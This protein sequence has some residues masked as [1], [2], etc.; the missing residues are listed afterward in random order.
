MKFNEVIKRITGL[1]TPVFGISWNP[2][3]TDRDR[4]KS[5]VAFLEDRR[6]LYN[7]TEMEVPHRC[8]QSILEIRGFL[9]EQIGRIENQEFREIL[10]GMRAACRKF[11][12]SVG[13]REDIVQHG[14]T[15]GHW[16]SW[17]FNGAVGELRG[18]FGIH[19]VKI[20]A[21]YGLDIEND[22]SSILP[23]AEG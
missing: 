18:V 4:A 23:I 5:I 2:E 22:L 9:T 21:M 7:P 1:S 17:A 13:E 10:K 11:L 3:G 15:A 20:A 14:N 16:A 12:D 19:I 6:V 8:V